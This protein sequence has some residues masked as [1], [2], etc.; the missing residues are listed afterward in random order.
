MDPIYL[1]IVIILL[2]LAALDLIVG[3]ANDASSTFSIRV[4]VQT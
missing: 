4:S 2:G 1:I 3:V